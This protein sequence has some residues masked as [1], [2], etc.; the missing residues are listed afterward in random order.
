MRDESN[1]SWSGLTNQHLV[2]TDKTASGEISM[3]S[4]TYIY[5]KPADGNGGAVDR[6]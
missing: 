1:E 4:I 3:Q 5:R 6:P 2:K